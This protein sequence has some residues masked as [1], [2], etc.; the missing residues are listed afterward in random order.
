MKR[1]VILLALIAGAYISARA[2]LWRTDNSIQS[3]SS[4][5]NQNGTFFYQ[6]NPNGNMGTSPNNAIYKN[7]SEFYNKDNYQR[8]LFPTANGVHYTPGSQGYN[9]NGSN[10]INN[11]TPG[12]YN[13]Q[14]V[15]GR[16][17]PVYN[18][19]DDPNRSNKR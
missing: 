6:P 18:Y 14:D 4:Y 11:N 13:N 9:Y 8:T 2:Q 7:Q 3:H 12:S 15:N 19:Q 10:Y 16:Q 1:L 5:A 17:T